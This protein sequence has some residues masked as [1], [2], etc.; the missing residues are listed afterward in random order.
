[1]TMKQRFLRKTAVW[2]AGVAFALTAAAAQAEEPKKDD[3]TTKRQRHVATKNNGDLAEKRARL[4][5]KNNQAPIPTRDGRNAKYV[6]GGAAG[7]ADG[8]ERAVLTG[9]KIPRTYNRRGYTT[10]SHDSQFIYDK[11]DIRLRST[12]NVSDSLRSVPGLTVRGG[13]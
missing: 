13:R 10:D 11:N 7:G 5:K 1:M 8:T 2:F 4:A 12:N 3:S 6:E 9:S